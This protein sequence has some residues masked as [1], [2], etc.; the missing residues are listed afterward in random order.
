MIIASAIFPSAIE[1]GKD[2]HSYLQSAVSRYQG[3]VLKRGA[4]SVTSAPETL[5]A[6]K[7]FAAAGD[8]PSSAVSRKSFG[9]TGRGSQRNHVC[10]EIGR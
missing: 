1:N 10:E 5:E 9:T 7:K 2:R 4:S 6:Q 3:R 8:E